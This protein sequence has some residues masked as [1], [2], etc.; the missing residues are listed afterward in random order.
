MQRVDLALGGEVNAVKRVSW[1][2]PVVYCNRHDIAWALHSELGIWI[3][4]NCE[5]VERWV[6]DVERVNKVGLPSRDD[7]Q[8]E[9]SYADPC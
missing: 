4:A 7:T 5:R 6:E 8:R 3:E 1:V 9:E 2:R